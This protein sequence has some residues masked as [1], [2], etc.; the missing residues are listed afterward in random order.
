MRWTDV[1][2]LFRQA[3]EEAP[4]DRAT[5]L[6]DACGADTA[7]RRRVQELL[8]AHGKLEA[9]KSDFLG[10]L[11]SE[12]ATALLEASRQD[13]V[14]GEHLGRYRIVRVLGRG[15]TCVVYQ[16]HDPELN[17][18]VALKVL[19][20]GAASD[21]LLDEA[22]AASALD[23]PAIGTVF[24]VGRTEEGGR[25]IA[26][27][28]YDEGTLRDRLRS[29]PVSPEEA[30][31]VLRQVAGG[32]AAAHGQGIVHRDLKPENLVF[33]RRGA[34][35]L[36]DFGLV[37]SRAGGTPGY[38]SPEQRD[39][40]AADPRVDV[41][42]FGV[43]AY[44]MLTG[45]R[46]DEESPEG[47]PLGELPRDAPPELTHLVR[48]CLAP[49]VATRPESG[50]ALM[51]ALAP[52]PETPPAARR[53]PG[54]LALLWMAAGVVVAVGI[55]FLTRG[56]E[57]TL[58]LDAQGSAQGMFP[59]RGWVVVADF[60]GADGTEDLALAAR[61]ALAVDL[62]QSAF[63]RVASR[64][65]IADVLG[66]MDLD[67]DARL[68]LPLAMEV[69][70]RFGAGSVLSAT[71]SR[72][73]PDFVLSGRAFDPMTGAEVFAVRTAAPE[74]A[75]LGAVERLARE[76]RARLGESAAELA[77][78]RP[79]PEVTTSSIEA[80]RLYAE[81]ERQ[82]TV[83]HD[84]A[85]AL[86]TAAVAADSTFAMAHRLAAANAT[87][88][89]SFGAAAE[90]LE[91]AYRFRERLPE[92]E[93]WHVEAI[94]HFQV[95][96][97]PELAIRAYEL[98]VDRYPDDA[99]AWNNLGVIRQGWTGDH[100]GALEAF[101]QAFALDSSNA[102]YVSNLV[103]GNY[104]VG[105]AA[106][107]DSMAARAESL[108]ITHHTLR[109]SVLRGFA[110]RRDDLVVEGC[111][112]LLA[113]GEAPVSTAEDG[114]ICGSMDVVSR[115]TRDAVERLTAVRQRSMEQGR[116]RNATHAAHS[117]AMA[118]VLAGDTAAAEAELRWVLDQMP[119]GQLAESDRL[120]VRTNM[121][122]H[123]HLLGFSSLARRVTAHFP[124]FS[125]PE[126]W[127]ARHGEGL[128]QAAAAVGAGDGGGALEALDHS[129]RPGHHPIG[130]QIW[131]ELLRG[132]ASELVGD[133][134]AA[135]RH[136]EAASDPAM[137]T[138]PFLTKNRIHRTTAEE[139][140]ARVRARSAGP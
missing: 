53:L 19:P 109:W 86:L 16:G 35:K 70:E 25:F 120:V 99:R 58:L 6:D 96:F 13:L 48:L 124:A 7:L 2:R 100:V 67:G 117:L 84:R 51:E 140:L 65:Q 30:L 4:A 125:E 132:L 46:P 11:D 131:D 33:D 50:E 98:L 64:A 137:M 97:E 47:G 107:A 31:E 127:F 78:S 92:R 12:R 118:R 121:A 56:N 129:I 54:R 41:W 28:P 40:R 81:A 76:M 74:H 68:D 87:S 57:P 113:A 134:E 133:F 15:G 32:L 95:E 80:L 77:Q 112:T 85:A 90:H 110:E 75:L 128:I 27:A 17:R 89:L 43:V 108:G 139:G 1:E 91:R 5:W 24:E 102:A 8:D 18:P 126:H 45:R 14:S 130:W 106:R 60:D 42:A 38:M 93:R 116:L 59:E 69:A 115:R 37:G 49:D 55:G 39:G 62:Q 66:R 103:Q 36:V 63:V 136:F 138:L 23:H 104:T 34:V 21:R 22:R 111:R 79:L 94:H 105:K 61:E 82:M 9:G 135:A 123:A 73:G 122:V 71:I 88:L 44:E 3:L 26:M 52:R 114:E 20:P 29:G 10:A 101:E 72:A 83:D 119:V